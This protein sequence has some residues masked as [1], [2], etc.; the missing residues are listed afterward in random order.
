MRSPAAPAPPA[1]V[2]QLIREVTEEPSY[3]SYTIAQQLGKEFK[4]LKQS[5]HQARPQRA[6]SSRT[7]EWRRTR[8]VVAAVGEGWTS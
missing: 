1:C 8:V 3:D 7:D 5:P 6:G 4:H 2:P